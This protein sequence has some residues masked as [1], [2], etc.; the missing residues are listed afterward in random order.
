MATI[1]AAAIINAAAF[2][3]QDEAGRRWARAELLGYVN[4]GQRDLCVVKP[5]AC[6]VNDKIQLVPGP[7]QAIPANGTAFM[8]LSCNLGVNGT[9]RGRAPRRFAIELMDRQN[10]NWQADAPSQTVME[11]GFDE[12]DPKHFYVSPPQ[13]ANN[14]AFVEA[15]FAAVPSDLASEAEAIAI[16]DVYKTALTHYVLY[17]AYLKDGELQDGGAAAAHR[18]EFLSLLGAKDKAEAEGA[19]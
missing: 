16:D 5:D 19:Q 13:P 2:A 12:R 14:P 1:L 4:D 11:Y 8:R 10:P 17:R 3:L 6:V 15:V 18:A 7:K 9:K